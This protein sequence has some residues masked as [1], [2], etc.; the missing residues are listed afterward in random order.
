MSGQNVSTA[1]MQRR[2]PTPEGSLGPR[3][4]PKQLD[5]FPTPPWA[6]RAACAF[7]EAELGEQ[8]HELE[9][10]EPACGEG[11]LARG[12][13]D[14]FGCVHASDVREYRPGQAVHDFLQAGRPPFRADWIF[15]N[16]PF[17]L[18]AEFIDTARRIARRGVVMFVR[19]AFTESGGRY[20]TMFKPG[21]DA[22]SYVVSYCERV[23]LLRDRLIQA[24]ALDPFNLDD[25]GNPS[26]ASSATAYGLVIWQ[27]G[28]NDTRH[29]WIRPCR[30]EFE[31]DGDY[32]A[33]AEQWEL[34]RQLQDGDSDQL[35]L[36]S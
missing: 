35:A 11:H 15:T 5:Y 27:P 31:R 1:V 32:P 6:A 16:P 25:D 33:Y 18:A 8:L 7:L 10:W 12:L 19:S 13:V 34:V 9:A 14:H 24:N 3:G 23:V 29:R 26:R 21:P 28:Q 17:Q 22:P 4:I 30:A 2:A 20:D 36:F